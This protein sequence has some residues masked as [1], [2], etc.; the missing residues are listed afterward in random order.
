MAYT[1]IELLRQHLEFTQPVSHRISDQQLQ[2]LDDSYVRF[3][4]GSIQKKSVTVKNIQ[5]TVQAKFSL[6]VGMTKQQFSSVPLVPGSLLVTTDS[7]LGTIYK[8]NIDFIINYSEG[9]FTAIDTGALTD[10]MQLILFAVPYTVYNENQDYRINYDTGSIQRIISGNILPG[11]TVF[12]DYLPLNS[13]HSDALLNN[14]VLEANA[15][16]EMTVDPNRQFGANIVLQTAAT[17]QAMEILCR[18]SAA[19]ELASGTKDDRTAAVWIKLSELYLTRSR[20]LI[21]SFV[22]PFKG[23]SAPTHS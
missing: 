19:R 14:A 16:I 10:G 6:T 18:A 21:E 22:E 9:T 23:P 13:S 11:E 1:N 4:N 12:L 3:Y 8:E 20:N 17:Y 2:I 7:S 15:I 5:S